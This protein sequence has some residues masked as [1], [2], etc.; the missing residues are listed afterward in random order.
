MLEYR[1]AQKSLSPAG[2]LASDDSDTSHAFLDFCREL[3]KPPV[4]LI[5]R[6]KVFGFLPAA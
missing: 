1:A 3:G 2:V 6:V 4:F 5:D